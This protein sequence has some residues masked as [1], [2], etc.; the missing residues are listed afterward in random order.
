MVLKSDGFL[1]VDFDTLVAILGHETLN[2]KETV[3]FD[4][5]IRWAEAEC[6]W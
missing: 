3:V 2:V 6:K 4:N 5:C 1:N